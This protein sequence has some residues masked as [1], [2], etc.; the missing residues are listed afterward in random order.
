MNTLVAK[1][2]SS[3]GLSFINEES[4][5]EERCQSAE[6]SLDTSSSSP[7]CAGEHD[8]MFSPRKNCLNVQ[9]VATV[10]RP[11]LALVTP[12]YSAV[13]VSENE[14]YSRRFNSS[15]MESSTPKSI[16]RPHRLVSTPKQL[17]FD[18]PPSPVPSPKS[19]CVSTSGSYHLFE[20]PA[21]AVR[22]RKE[23]TRYRLANLQQR[24]NSESLF[25]ITPPIDQ[26]RR[27]SVAHL[28]YKDQALLRKILGPQGLSWI[29][30]D[31]GDVSS[32]KS[33]SIAFSNDLE[34]QKVGDDSEIPLM[35]SKEEMIR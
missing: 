6:D 34:A 35:E 5:S 16:L 22:V 29:G 1:S 24:S 25:A 26:S 20:R 18:I 17:S 14:G 23:P 19:S 11:D 28:P 33:V 15:P 7:H 4:L 21:R 27:L 31:K 9:G 2:Y 8:G 10:H 32:K 3:S 12:E 13:D 30:S